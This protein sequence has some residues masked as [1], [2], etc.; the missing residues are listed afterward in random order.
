MFGNG[1]CGARVLFIDDA[2]EGIV[3]TLRNLSFNVGT[4]FLHPTHLAQLMILSSIQSLL[5]L[6]EP[7]QMDKWL[8]VMNVSKMTQECDWTPQTSLRE[9]LERT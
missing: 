2:V 8:K 7:S 4:A 9:G 1:I 3:A 5:Y 6:I